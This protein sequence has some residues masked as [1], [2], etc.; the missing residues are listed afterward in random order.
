MKKGKE[1]RGTSKN[2]DDDDG[3]TKTSITRTTRYRCFPYLTRSPLKNASSKKKNPQQLAPI[4][5][6]P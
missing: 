6:C 4:P 1:L 2:K 5:F 3:N